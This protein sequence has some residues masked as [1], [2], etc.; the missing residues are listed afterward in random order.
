L[1]GLREN[2]RQAA[3]IEE[4]NLAPASAA[5][6]IPAHVSHPV[7]RLPAQVPVLSQIFP[8]ETPDAG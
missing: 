3:S 4:D 7:G 1:S 2:A 8:C 6:F 5:W